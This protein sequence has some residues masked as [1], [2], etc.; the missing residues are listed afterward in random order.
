MVV[1]AGSR[2]KYMYFEEAVGLSERLDAI[3]PLSLM[4]GLVGLLLIIHH[5]RSGKANSGRVVDLGSLY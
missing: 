5:A 3:T 4:G 2:Q 1:N